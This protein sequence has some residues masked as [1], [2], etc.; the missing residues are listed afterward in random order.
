VE[1]DLKFQKVTDFRE[2]VRSLSWPDPTRDPTWPE[3]NRPD[4]TWSGLARPDLN[5]T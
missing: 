5:L 4:L 2:P 1:L 3:P